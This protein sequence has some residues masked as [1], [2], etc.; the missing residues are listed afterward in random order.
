[1]GSKKARKLGWHIACSAMSTHYLSPRFEIHCG[2]GDL[3]FFSHYENKN[4]QTCAPCE[5]SGV[6]YW[7]LNGRVMMDDILTVREVCFLFVP[8]SHKFSFFFVCF[9]V[10]NCRTVGSV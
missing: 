1:M 3:K 7:L 2:G 6:N 4:A 10:A 9:F 8:I 5:D